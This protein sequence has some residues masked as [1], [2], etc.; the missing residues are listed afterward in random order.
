MTKPVQSIIH[1]IAV[2]MEEEIFKL[3]NEG[4]LEGLCRNCREVQAITANAALDLIRG[5]AEEL[6]EIMCKDKVFRQ[7]QGLKIHQ[8]N[9]ERTVLLSIGE[10]KYKRTSFKAEGQEGLV[11]PVDNYLGID[12][13]FFC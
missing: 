6:D 4:G 7:E 11:Y 9:I 8:R 3:F 10:L 1:Q 12:K 5:C 13:R 2:R